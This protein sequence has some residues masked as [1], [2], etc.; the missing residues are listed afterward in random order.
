M[1]G[2]MTL[3][4]GRW[5][6]ALVAGGLLLHAG[7]AAHAQADKVVVDTVET[8][9]GQATTG[10]VLSED[11]D[12]LELQIKPGSKK[13]IEWKDVTNVQYG[14]AA[15][16]TE[17][18]GKLGAT[19]VAE[20]LDAFGRFKAD[21]KLRPVIKQQVLFRIATLQAKAGDFDAAAAAWLELATAFPGG[22][23]LDQAARGAVDA[24]LAKGAP[25]EAAKALEAVAA[26]AK[27]GNPGPRFDTM[28]AVLRARLLEAQGNV[29]G[30]KAAYEAAEASGTLSGEQAAFAGLGIARCLRQANDLSGAEARFRKLVDS[31][32]SPRLV[33]AGAWNGLG[34]LLLEQGR[35]KRDTEVLTLALYDYL[36]GVVV[37]LPLD[38]ES[39]AEHQ[40][41]LAGAALCCESIAQIDA[42]PTVKQAYSQRASELREKSKKLYPNAK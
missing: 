14:G 10:K 41:A 34:E 3:R 27:P 13:K 36:R 2:S 1:E 23:Y 20:A 35:K 21:A 24:Q 18:V 39:T 19:P 28:V 29:A 15:E 22:R 25:A 26:A 5:A 12:G 32:D 33:L 17:L 9:T 16:F 11:Y 37:Y 38:G 31:A 4:I 30:A 42:N 40:A 8:T 6:R 7:A